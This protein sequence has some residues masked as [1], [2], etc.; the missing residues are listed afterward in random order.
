MI[1]WCPHAGH[2][3][4]SPGANRAA[5]LA[6]VPPRERS[7][8]RRPLDRYGSGWS[9]NGY[10]V[11][12]NTSPSSPLDAAHSLRLG[13]AAHPAVYD[14]NERRP[15]VSPQSPPVGSVIE[16]PA[17]AVTCPIHEPAHCRCRTSETSRQKVP[18]GA[19][20]KYA[21]RPG[22]ERI[23]PLRAAGAANE[24]CRRRDR[25]IPRR[26]HSL[27]GW[28]A[29]CAVGEDAGGHGTYARRRLRATAR[30]VRQ[31]TG[32]RPRGGRPDLSTL[33]GGLDT[34]QLCSPRRPT[35]GKRLLCSQ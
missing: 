33:V 3:A 21:D 2:T 10:R 12:I 30:P 13:A 32:R 7:A 28:P 1:S 14:L 27:G 24:I 9:N 20:I 16:L 29:G 4:A 11:A 34:G 6:S 31:R 26:E 25:P 22:L 35:Q 19:I 8:W 23:S 15:P 5:G 17:C 18:S